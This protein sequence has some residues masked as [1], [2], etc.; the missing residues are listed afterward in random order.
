MPSSIESF[1][2]GMYFLHSMNQMLSRNTVAITLIAVVSLGIGYIWGQGGRNEASAQVQ[3]DT[4]IDRVSLEQIYRAVFSR[5]LDDGAEFHV[6]KNL[7]TVLNDL[8][9]SPERRYYAALF[10]AV[11][12]YEEALRAPGTLSDSDKQAYLKAIESALATL[13]AWAETLPPKDI[14]MGITRPEEVKE[15][16]LEAY[17]KIPTAFQAEAERG[18]FNSAA[19]GTPAALTL[20]P[21]RCMTPWPT[22]SPWVTPTPTPTM[23]P[24]ASP[25]A[26]PTP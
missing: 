20:P 24:T 21:G 9:N 11:K 13:A 16:I 3:T 10:K 14:C 18:L 6:N 22:S 15:A 7:R 23:S 2:A 26:S 17:N 5:A 8:N 25:T 1:G 19:L 4:K 12:A